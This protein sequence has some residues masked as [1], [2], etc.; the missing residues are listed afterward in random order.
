MSAK[1]QYSH[2][3]GTIVDGRIRDL[4]EHRDLGFPVFARATGTT[5]PGELLRVSEVCMRGLSC[6]AFPSP[7][8]TLNPDQSRGRTESKHNHTNILIHPSKI[9]V[10]VRLQSAD[11]EATISPGDYLI[12]DL[13][14]VVCLPKKLAEKTVALMASQVEADERVKVDIENGVGFEEASRKRRAGVKRAEDV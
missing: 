2:A 3:A 5:A 13:N 8:C 10:P 11:Q 1:A 12:G 9:N 14:G 6:S 4:Q 7:P